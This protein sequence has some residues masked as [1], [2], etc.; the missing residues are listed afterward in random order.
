MAKNSVSSSLTEWPNTWYPHLWQGGQP[1]SIPIFDWMAN[2]IITLSLTGW[3]NTYYLHLWQ[4]AWPY[5]FNDP[6]FGRMANHLIWG[7]QL[8]N[9][10]IPNGKWPAPVMSV[11]HLWPDGQTLS[12]PI[13]DQMA[14]HIITPSLAGWPNPQYHHLWLNGWPHNNPILDWIAKHSV[15]PSLTK[16]STI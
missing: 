4:G 7:G 12:I 3:L 13:F 1:L 10:L 6:I 2:H 5:K 8:L 14:N 15:S 9:N 16:W 11:L